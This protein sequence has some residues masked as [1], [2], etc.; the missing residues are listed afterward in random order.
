M[1]VSLNYVR[2]EICSIQYFLNIDFLYN[3]L[4]YIIK[5][6]IEIIQ[7]KFSINQTSSEIK[8]VVNKALI[9]KN[10]I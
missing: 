7:Y 4:E 2:Y 3:I 5:Y 6:Y 10:S 8:I 1:A 9:T